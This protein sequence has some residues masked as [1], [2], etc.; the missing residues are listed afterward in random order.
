MKDLPDA[1]PVYLV[2][3]LAG[4]RLQLYQELDDFDAVEQHYAANPNPLSSVSMAA[5]MMNK[6]QFDR[7][8]KHVAPLID[9]SSE[10]MF[11]PELRSKPMYFL[12]QPFENLAKELFK[13]N[14]PD[15][16]LT[17]ISKL[18][19]SRDMARAF[20]TFGELLVQSG[21]GAELEQW[22]TKLPHETAKTHARLGA[23]RE[24]AAPGKVDAVPKRP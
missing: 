4:I 24:I 17:F 11:P 1:D 21:R 18:P 8:W 2:G 23:L 12:A 15:D 6:G 3:N 22:L 13:A 10:T 9:M 16:A 7:G 14:R 20:E 19:E 5:W